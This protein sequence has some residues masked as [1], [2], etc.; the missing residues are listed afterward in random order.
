MCR[1]F[2]LFLSVPIVAFAQQPNLSNTSIPGYRGIWFELNQKYPFG[3]KYSGGLG[4]YTAKHQPLAIYAPGVNTT[5]FVYGGVATEPER[6]LLCMIGAFDHST[7][8][9]SKPVV[10]FDKLGVDDPHDNPS[11]SIDEEGYLWVFVSGRGNTRPGIKLRS[12]KPYDIAAFDEISRETF[13]YPQI[14]KTRK[15]FFHFFTQYSGVRELYFETS[16]DGNQWTPDVK[17][18]GIPQEAGQKAGHYQVSGVWK[19]SIVGTFF[20][21]HLNG[22]PDTRTDLYYAETRDFGRT[23]QTAAGQPL[24]LPLDTRD[25]PARVWDY[26]G[27]GLNNYMKD[28]AFDS[29]GRPVCLHLTSRG[30]E[31]GPENQ[32]YQWTISRWNGK[33]WQQILIARS[34]HNYD[35]GSLWINGAHW[36]IIAPFENRPQ[37]WGAGGEI[38]QWESFDDGRTWNK[39]MVLT[40][41][42]A[43]NH[44]Y[45]RRVINGKPPFQF[46]WA[47]GDP[48]RFSRSEL[49]F[50]DFEGNVWRL[51]Y[52]LEE[53]WGKPELVSRP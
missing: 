35:M 24:K 44:G 33:F 31:P 21:R 11:L 48:H 8:M 12:R 22:D 51:P 5:F 23:W 16:T 42:S 36:R 32:P 38:A 18:A 2:F 27:R 26:Y 20:N 41:N 6:H 10:V 46:F 17:L 45:V 13:T 43:R 39:T 47:D 19:D 29:R 50:G 4:T 3:D 52:D 34:D 25:A 9:V 37:P 49:Y 1:L 30:H 7:G 28:M 40:K 15:G 53:D 14:W